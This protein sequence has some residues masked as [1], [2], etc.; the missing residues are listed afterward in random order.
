MDDGTPPP[1][2]PAPPAATAGMGTRRLSAAANAVSEPP[3]T[4]EPARAPGSV[5][6]YIDADNQAAANAAQLARTCHL[7]LNG[8]P[9]EVHVA[10][11]NSGQRLEHWCTELARAL[12]DAAQN[13][14]EVP[15]RRNSA[16]VALIM[17]LGRNLDR[18]IARSDLIVVASRDDF[19]IC[20]AEHAQMRGARVL[21]A[22]SDTGVATARST[23]LT[24]LLL[25]APNGQ[26]NAGSAGKATADVP[27]AAPNGS[28][29]A[30]RHVL[31]QLRSMLSPQ[32]GGG[33]AASAVGHALRQLGYETPEQR[34]SFI[35]G[36]KAMRVAGSG[37][38]KRYLF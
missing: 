36:A 8:K 14:I 10:G 15:V 21:L 2:H 4:T 24:T 6:I 9:L 37:A 28:D 18:H 25:P 27:P 35:D 12:P 20:A 23:L 33:Y 29:T 19:L 22:Y 26:G 5:V 16:D 1:L 32:Q 13:R 11:N 31:A 34:R 3:R 17:E 30:E 38:D 7:D